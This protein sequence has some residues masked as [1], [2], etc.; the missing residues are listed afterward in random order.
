[1][2]G[3]KTLYS[4][5]TYICYVWVHVESVV[6]EVDGRKMSWLLS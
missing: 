2:I 3:D 6:E 4:V 5:V 1:M